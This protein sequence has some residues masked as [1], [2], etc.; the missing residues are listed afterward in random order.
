MTLVSFVPND[1]I[2]FKFLQYFIN[3][4]NDDNEENQQKL[5][6]NGDEVE[7]LLDLM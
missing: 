2:G 7:V 3:S 4:E 5:E 6:N 1:E